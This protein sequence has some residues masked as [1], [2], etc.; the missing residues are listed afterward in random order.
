MI[1][2]FAIVDPL[3]TVPLYLSMTS[4]STPRQRNRTARL[5][6]L[7]VFGVLV[8]SSLLGESILY[9]LGTSLGAFQVGGGIVLM[10][11][12]LGLLQSPALPFDELQDLP[13][14]QD[15]DSI[16]VVPL[17]IPLLAGPGA[18]S[19]VI[20]TA[21]RGEGIRHQLILWGCIGVVCVIVWA[22][23]RLAAQF[24]HRLSNL[25]LGIVNRLLGLILAAIAIQYIANGLKKLFPALAG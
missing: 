13:P 23:H 15:P 2:L 25:H 19:T 17:G 6:A 3:F 21:H 10:M 16:G 20:I 9:W 1:A 5:L 8:A 14:Q 7:T 18:I 12:A 4:G 22:T 24:G 11:V